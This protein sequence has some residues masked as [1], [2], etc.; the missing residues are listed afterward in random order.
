MT[1]L[2]VLTYVNLMP[3]SRKDNELTLHSSNVAALDIVFKLGELLL[4]FVHGDLV[5]LCC[6]KVS[7]C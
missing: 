2:I 3:G 7:K 1:H 4:Q 6:V 5:I